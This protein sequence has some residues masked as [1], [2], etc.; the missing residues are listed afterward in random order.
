M[1]EG[2]GP[3]QKVEELGLTVQTLTDE[4]AELFN[5]QAGQGVVVAA[6]TPDSIASQAGIESGLVVTQVNREPVTNA[7]EFKQA[8]NANRDERR[9]LLLVQKGGTQQYVVLR[10]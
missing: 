2:L 10:W 7:E 4:Q 5:V 9:L 8:V 6:V 1:T 3:T